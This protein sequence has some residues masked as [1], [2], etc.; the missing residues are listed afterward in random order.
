MSIKKGDCNWMAILKK[1]EKIG[2]GH[3]NIYQ[4]FTRKSYYSIFVFLIA[5]SYL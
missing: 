5:A 1:I 4:V 2:V 3:F